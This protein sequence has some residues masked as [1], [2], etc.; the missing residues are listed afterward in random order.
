MLDLTNLWILIE[1]H[2]S[3]RSETQPLCVTLCK[4][5]QV[6]VYMCVCVNV[7]DIMV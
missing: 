4:R 2:A 5:V 7:R 3:V 1:E 6:C